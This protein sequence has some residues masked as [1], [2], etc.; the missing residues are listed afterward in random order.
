MEMLFNLLNFNQEHSFTVAF[1]KAHYYI[2]IKDLL[3]GINMHY[4]KWNKHAL[5]NLTLC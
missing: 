2:I 3:S 1:L 4:I 5:Q